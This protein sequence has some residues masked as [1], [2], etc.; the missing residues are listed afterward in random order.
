M[1]DSDVDIHARLGSLA[2][3]TRTRLLLVLG[4]HELSVNEL[5]MA[6]QLPQST[7]SRHLKLLLDEGWLITRAEGPSRYYRLGTRL[8]GTAR[9]LW[10]VVRDD[11][12]ARPEA[13][14]DEARARR[15]LSLRRTRSQEF[16]STAAGQWDA[17]REEL[18]GA[19]AGLGGL[20]GLLPDDLVVGDLGCGTGLVALELARYA[21]RVVAVDESKAML[22]AARRR[23][24]GHDNVELRSGALE[25][26]PVAD[27]ELDAAVLSLVL[28][29]VAEPALALAEAHRALRPGGRLVVVDMAAHNRAEYRE[30]MGHMWQGFTEPQLG[31]WLEE[32][33]FTGV[34]WQA[35]DPEARAR[36]PLLFAVS[37]T[38]G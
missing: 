7:V 35:L 24:S 28:H 33:G 13:V 21:G 29:Y 38:K 20:L 1:N 36:G 25:A 6:L 10:H 5:C 32:A 14:Q 26:L 3:A 23:L 4:R 27:A 37:A 8:E 34:R 9:R 31:G 11:L 2:D 22:S 12:A 15:V 18:F 19:R 30:Q 16:F 17:L